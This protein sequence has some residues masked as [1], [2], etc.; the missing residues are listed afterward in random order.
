MNCPGFNFLD[1]S[2]GEPYSKILANFC[3]VVS[4]KILF[5]LFLSGIVFTVALRLFVMFCMI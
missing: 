4:G 3:I 5:K 1:L 2:S